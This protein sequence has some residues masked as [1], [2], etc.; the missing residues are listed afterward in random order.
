MS[1]PSS[2]ADDYEIIGSQFRDTELNQLANKVDTLADDMLLLRPFTSQTAKL[3]AIQERAALPG[4]GTDWTII[5]KPHPSPSAPLSDAVPSLT[6]SDETL[7]VDGV[8]SSRSQPIGQPE[9]KRGSP[10]RKDIYSGPECP[11]EAASH[12]RSLTRSLPSLCASP[13][14]MEGDS[15]PDA[16]G[17]A[18]TSR[19][20]LGFR[21]RN[22]SEHLHNIGL[23]ISSDSQ[24]QIDLKIQMDL[25]MQRNLHP[26]DEIDGGA[27]SDNPSPEGGEG[28]KKSVNEPKGSNSSGGVPKKR[29]GEEASNSTKRQRREGDE[30]GGDSSE[31]NAPNAEQPKVEKH[32]ACPYYKLDP[33]RHRRC[34]GH[35]LTTPSR[36]KQHLLRVHTAPVYCPRCLDT[37]TDEISL[38]QHLRDSNPCRLNQG[39]PPSGLTE[40][41]VSRLRSRV[42]KNYKSDR[43]HW[44]WIF[45]VLFPDAPKPESPYIDHNVG[46]DVTSFVEFGRTNGSEVFRQGLEQVLGSSEPLSPDLVRTVA[47]VVFKELFEKWKTDRTNNVVNE[48]SSASIIPFR[49]TAVA[50]NDH[51]QTTGASS[52]MAFANDIS[53]PCSRAADDPRRTETSNRLST[54][55]PGTTTE[56]QLRDLDNTKSPDTHATGKVKRKPL[57]TSS[58]RRAHSPDVAIAGDEHPGG[59][60]LATTL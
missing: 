13:S 29:N 41:E 51:P 21:G 42:G 3:L 54:A 20:H 57:P 43:E 17:F 39:N 4:L 34:Y 12:P 33:N 47:D 27:P 31:S 49:T 52:S 58:S 24:L 10:D 15:K 50:T 25:E 40:K 30:G 7:S 9:K 45:G 28:D 26:P 38:S 16:D 32:L 11:S 46:E 1:T 59:E 44:Y 36:V 2:V 60:G 23:N 55:S 19:L 5:P 56:W 37:F 14:S 53:F 22:G 35:I 48:N 8:Q 18:N 6:R